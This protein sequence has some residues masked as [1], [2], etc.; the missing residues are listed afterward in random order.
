MMFG[1]RVKEKFT[2]LR[3]LKKLTLRLENLRDSSHV[4][5]ALSGESKQNGLKQM[6][7]H[8]HTQVKELTFNSGRG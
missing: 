4:Q 8:T 5:T 3:W 7:T 1:L 6:H 2:H